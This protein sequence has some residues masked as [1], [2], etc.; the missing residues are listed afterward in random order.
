MPGISGYRRSPQG[1]AALFWSDGTLTTLESTEPVSTPLR[2]THGAVGVT[3]AGA[4]LKIVRNDTAAP[5]SAP[6]AGQAH[7]LGTLIVRFVVLLTI[8]VGLMVLAWSQ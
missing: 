1:A 2:H 5:M 4:S 6:R 8:V 7:K 3:A